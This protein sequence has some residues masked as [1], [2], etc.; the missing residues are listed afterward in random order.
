MTQATTSNLRWDDYNI[1]KAIKKNTDF[2]W[3]EVTAVTM[4]GAWKDLCCSLFMIFVDLRRG[5]PGPTPRA[6]GLS[7]DMP[8]Q[9]QRKIPGSSGQIQRS[10]VGPPN[11]FVF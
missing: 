8:D 1:H 6:D 4:N 7:S 5:P 10:Y 3:C 9:T 2:A 11:S